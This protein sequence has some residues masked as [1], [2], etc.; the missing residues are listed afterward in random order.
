MCA[1]EDAYRHAPELVADLLARIEDL[2][3]GTTTDRHV[4]VD[5]WMLVS[6]VRYALG[7]QTYITGQTVSEVLR[8]WPD[9]DQQIRELIIRDVREVHDRMFPIDRWLWDNITDLEAEL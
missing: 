2:E 6:A 8:L 7:R 5:Q 4:A 3:R 9:L 1:A